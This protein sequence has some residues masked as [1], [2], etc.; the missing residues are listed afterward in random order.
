MVGSID[1]QSGYRGIKRA[2][3]GQRLSGCRVSV[4]GRQSPLEADGN[5]AAVADAR[6]VTIQNGG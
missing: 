2:G 5:R 1:R 4:A 3:T 6:K